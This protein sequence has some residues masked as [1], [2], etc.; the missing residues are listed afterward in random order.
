[1]GT[2]TGGR[3]SIT[4]NAAGG[5]E[6]AAVTEADIDEVASI[7]GLSFT[8]NILGIGNNWYE[9]DH[10]TKTY[11]VAQVTYVITTTEGNYAKFQIVT[12]SGPGGESFWSIFEYL[13]QDDDSGDFDI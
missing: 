10:D 11:S 7:D 3:S 6:V 2:S 1:M 4:I 5:V 8:G 12:F 13:Y 9:F